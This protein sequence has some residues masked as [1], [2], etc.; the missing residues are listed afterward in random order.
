MTFDLDICDPK[1]NSSRD[2]NFY[3][4]NELSSVTDGQTGGQTDRWTD[5]R[6]R[7]STGGLN[8]EATDMAMSNIH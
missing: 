6:W 1:S 5:R 3:L 7:M 8:N 4:V 2:K